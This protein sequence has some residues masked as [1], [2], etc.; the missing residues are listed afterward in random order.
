M[1]PARTVKVQ[2]TQLAVGNKS[3]TSNHRG[4]TAV[5]WAN[6]GFVQRALGASGLS[7]SKP[8]RRSG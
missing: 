1:S 7:S 6:P 3:A 2:I 5:H 8:Q 4:R